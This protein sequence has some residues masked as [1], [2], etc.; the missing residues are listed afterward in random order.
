MFGRMMNETLGKW[1]C[2]L[3]FIFMNLTF[4]PMHFLGIGGHPRRYASLEYHPTM[5]HLKQL[6]SMV[7]IC[8]ILT[9]LSQLIFYVNVIYSIY[10][11][12]KAERNPW[13]ANSL[14]WT[15]TPSPPGHGIFEGPFPTVYRPPYE[16]AS[17]EV[18]EDWLPQSKYLE[19]ASE[20]AKT[21]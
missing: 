6:T 3:T 14:E 19:S 10:W 2:I 13:Q 12:P 18:E 17:P 4:G 7:T 16:Y 21:H 1:H 8:A 11:G 15:D 9:G 20:E 5:W